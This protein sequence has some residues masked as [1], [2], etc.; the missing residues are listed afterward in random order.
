MAENSTTHEHTVESISLVLNNKIKKFE[1]NQITD[2]KDEDEKIENIDVSISLPFYRSEQQ[3][4]DQ[5][6]KSH[7]KI[8]NTLTDSFFKK[9][10][11]YSLFLFS[12]DNLIRRFCKYLTNQKWFENIIFLIVILNCITLAIER[13]SILPSSLVSKYIFI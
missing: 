1:I 8:P 7:N 3:T 6:S 5:V 2:I 13:P 11:E 4:D 9:W 12:N 10:A